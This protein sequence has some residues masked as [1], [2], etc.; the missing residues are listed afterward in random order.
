MRFS[1]LNKVKEDPAR[2]EPLKKAPPAAAPAPVPE[3]PEP[4][5]ARPAET[6]PASPA[7]ADRQE[8]IKL[9]AGAYKPAPRKEPKA[10]QPPQPPFREQDAAAREVY[11]LMLNQAGELLKGADQAYT[12]KYEAVLRACDLAVST[13]KENPV[14]LNYAAYSTAE[15]YLRAHS[16]NTA[17]IAL[18]LGLAAG[19]EASELRLLG[20]CAMAHDIGMTGYAD[21]YDREDRLSD[22]EF[23]R[24]T[25]HAEAG[26]EK[27][28]RI[29]DI[30]YKIK[31]RA[32][33][34]ISQ[35]HERMDGSGYP[36]R[37][38]SEGIDPLAQLIGIADVYEAMTHPR[39]WRE[40]M[41][42]PD[43]VKEL[44][45]RENHGFSSGTVKALI[46]ALSIYPP[47]SLVTL[48]TGE[49]AKVIRLNK[50]SL[51]R[52]LVE[53]LLSPDFAQTP[54]KTVDLLEY[55][56]TS[57]ENPANLAELRER[58]PKYAGKLELARW[59]V[60]W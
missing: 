42:P 40:A 10:A 1:D 49:I 45:E 51:T 54:P 8:A 13:L 44:I 38:S 56:L 47:S 39:T 32:K 60:E 9:H 30:D 21:L 33:R 28:D 25:L 53:I 20:F 16:A 48:S 4:E 17:V 37:V 2:K 19:L 59:W 27:L 34:I 14:L 15:D 57:I 46:S 24:I 43:V 50:G 29:V 31:D 11:T 22:E 3:K 18:A 35:I 55:P 58:N 41:N 12:E 6:A 36:D 26:V 5:P 23:S 52:P 7:G